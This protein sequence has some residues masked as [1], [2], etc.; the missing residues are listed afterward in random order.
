M[1]T[2]ILL[3]KDGRFNYYRG[4]RLAGW[5]YPR[6]RFVRVLTPVF[7]KVPQYVGAMCRCSV[8]EYSG[9]CKDCPYSYQL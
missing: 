2:R 7:S 5:Y 4:N 8:C 9:T 1:E 3:S 6:S